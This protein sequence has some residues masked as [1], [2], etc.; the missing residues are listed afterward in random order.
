MQLA[1]GVS[2]GD[3]INKHLPP[4]PH[5]GFARQDAVG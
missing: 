1:H 3:G 2:R 5:L 4:P